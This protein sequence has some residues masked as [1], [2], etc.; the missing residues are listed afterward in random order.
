MKQLSLDK[1]YL[2]ANSLDEK[3]VDF[4]VSKKASARSYWDLKTNGEMY[5]SY[6][7]HKWGQTVPILSD[8]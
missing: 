5:L 6:S 8:C 7:L 4:Q 2:S 3:R 1:L